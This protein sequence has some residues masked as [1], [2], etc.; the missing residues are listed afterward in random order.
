MVCY[1]DAQHTVES[2]FGLEVVLL[3]AWN[4][5]SGLGNVEPYY[6]Y[7]VIRTGPAAGVNALNVLHEYAHGFVNRAVTENQSQAQALSRYFKANSNATKQGYDNWMAIVYESFVR[8]ISIYFDSTSSQSEKQQ[9]LNKDIN[10]GFVMTKYVYE[11]IPEFN[12]FDGDFDAF[13][14]MLL[15]EYPQYA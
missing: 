4:R 12:T 10:D 5:G 8:G 15:I 14:K 11:R 7:G 2:E 6:G 9:M 3:D 13:I 1:F